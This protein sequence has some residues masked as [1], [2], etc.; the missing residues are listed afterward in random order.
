MLQGL[1]KFSKEQNEVICGTNGQVLW[2]FLC[3]HFFKNIHWSSAEVSKL[4][5]CKGPGSKYFRVCGHMHSV[6]PLWNEN[7]HRQHVTVWALLC[8]DKTLL[9][10]NRPWARLVLS[11]CNYQPLVCKEGLDLGVS[12]C[13]DWYFCCCDPQDTSCLA[14][15][16]V[17]KV[18]STYLNFSPPSQ[19]LLIV[20]LIKR[21]FWII[22]QSPASP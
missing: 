16:E 19:L 22:K 20:V 1:A 7:S 21:A 2:R 14:S 8:S 3:R 12:N 15:G 10:K 13:R 5:F 6:L 4:F 17:K 18:R 9:I 11:G